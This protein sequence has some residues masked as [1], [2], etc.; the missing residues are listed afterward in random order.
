MQTYDIEG[1]MADKSNGKAETVCKDTSKVKSQDQRNEGT[2]GTTRTKQRKEMFK[3]TRSGQPVM[4]YRI[5]KILE[6]IKK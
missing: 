1:L 4:K 5:Q 2:Q 3:K 6:E